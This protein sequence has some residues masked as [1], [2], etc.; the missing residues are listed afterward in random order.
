MAR[1]IRSTA[2]AAL[3]VLA[4]SPL[5]AASASQDTRGQVAVAAAAAAPLLSPQAY[6]T[7]LT[8]EGQSARCHIRDHSRRQQREIQ[9]IAAI[10]GQI[11]DCPGSDRGR[12]GTH[13]WGILQV[14]DGRTRRSPMRTEN[15]GAL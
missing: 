1:G 7:A 9:K 12:R 4:I 8:R 5:A 14:L 10:H 13:V 15:S 3:L 11:A 2:C 6:L